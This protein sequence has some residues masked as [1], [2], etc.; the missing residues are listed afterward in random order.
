MKWLPLLGLLLTLLALAQGREPRQAAPLVNVSPGG[1]GIRSIDAV[2]RTIRVDYGF[3][4]GPTCNDFWQA[5]GPKQSQAPSTAYRFAFKTTV[6]LGIESAGVSAKVASIS[7]RCND[8][9][10]QYQSDLRRVIATA[11]LTP[12]LNINDLYNVIQ[13]YIFSEN[14]GTFSDTFAAKAGVD[15][16]FTPLYFNY[17]DGTYPICTVGLGGCGRYLWNP[18]TA[19]VF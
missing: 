2:S 16:P 4:G 6:E 8:P 14:A 12:D 10:P 19:D 17:L 15:S 9:A 5:S 1:V 11:K 7:L 3:A 13:G 18:N